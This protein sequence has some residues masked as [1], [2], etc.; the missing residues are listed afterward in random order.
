MPV[1]RSQAERRTLHLKRKF[2]RDAKFHEDYV[3]FL[4]E[5]I[6]E[7]YEEK[8]PPDVLERSDG[9]VWIMPHH[10]VYH[11]KKPDK[12]RVVFDCSP[13]PQ[14]TS[15]NNEL[16]QGPDLAN[17]LVGV[18]IR[19][20]QEPVAVMGDFQSMSHQVRVPEADRDLVRF[21][22]VASR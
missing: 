15:L 6:S 20:G 5:V 22:L 1:N 11:H 13:Q 21:L 3:T 10:S 17:N 12:I 7:G 14:E 19:F 8:V 18:L 2:S 4:E 9:K 16:F